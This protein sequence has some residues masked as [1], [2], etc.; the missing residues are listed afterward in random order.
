MTDPLAGKRQAINDYD[1]YSLLW[2]DRGEKCP[3]QVGEIFELRSCFIEITK[4]H[5]ITHEGEKKWRAAFTRIAKR[6]DR[7]LFLSRVGDYTDDPDQAVGLREDVFHA[8]APNL[9]A[10]EEEAR[11]DAHKNEGDP[12]EPEPVPPHEVRDLRGSRDA[13]QRYLRDMAEQRGTE[14]CAP[15]EERLARLREASRQRHVDVSGEL[16]IVEK[17]IAKAE[18]KVLDRAA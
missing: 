18:R 6:I 2:P 16:R 13:Q 17:Q 5:R 12:L 9:D 1:L 14:E 8:S 4:T 10:I 11:S 15:L 7:P 3:V